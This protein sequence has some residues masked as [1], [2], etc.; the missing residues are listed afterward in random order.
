MVFQHIQG[1]TNADDRSAHIPL[2]A[3][4]MSVRQNGLPKKKAYLRRSVMRALVRRC[5]AFGFV[6]LLLG[7][8]GMRTAEAAQLLGCA[9][10]NYVHFPQGLYLSPQVPVQNVTIG[11]VFASCT[12]VG[13]GAVPVKFVW[14]GTVT[15]PSCLSALNA[16]STGAGIL[17]WDDNTSSN[18]TLDSV[19]VIGAVG[20][21]PSV[22]RFKINSGHGSGGSFTVVAAFLTSTNNV[23]SC[24]LGVPVYYVGGV[25][26]NNFVDLGL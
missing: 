12:P 25:S 5:L 21:T 9:S 19:I 13:I 26:S 4:A 17:D 6:L 22:A 11:S 23:T 2:A 16:V 3:F 20:V 7:T 18:V 8:T 14:N 10:S 15:G 1:G 24:L